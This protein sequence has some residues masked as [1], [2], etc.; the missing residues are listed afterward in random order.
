MANNDEYESR[1]TMKKFF[2]ILLTAAILN[3]CSGTQEV[4]EQP[5]PEPPPA[6]SVSPPSA[7]PQNPA[8]TPVPAPEQAVGQPAARETYGND[9]FRNVTV[10]KTGADTYEIKGQASVFEGVF[11]YVVEDG[12]NELT[13]GF[14]QT[15]A[16]APEWGDF[17]HTL[18]VKKAEPNSTLTLI[19]FEIS[20][21]DGSRRM[22]LIIPLPEK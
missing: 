15:S 21:K 20:A 12:H 16:G 5:A 14:V 4:V 3:G 1:D 10:A 19:L 13:E 22:E 17:T 7:Q 11:N 8:P 6:T 18:T 9:I 2:L